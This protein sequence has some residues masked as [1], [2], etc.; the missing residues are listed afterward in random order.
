MGYIPYHPVNDPE[1]FQQFVN[2]LLQALDE[3]KPWPFPPLVASG[4][5]LITGSHRYAAAAEVGWEYEDLPID[6]V[7]LDDIFL[8]AGLDF[9]TLHAEHG[10]PGID[11]SDELIE[12]LAELPD[13]ILRKYGIDLH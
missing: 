6:I 7:Q 13:D 1:K 5:F 9:E 2:I 10:S 4:E 8:E 12:L 11:G 3:E